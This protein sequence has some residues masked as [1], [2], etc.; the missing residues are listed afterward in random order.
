MG[1]LRGSPGA[2]RAGDVKRKLTD[3]PHGCKVMDDSPAVIIVQDEGGAYKRSPRK[4]GAEEPASSSRMMQ[5]SHRSGAGSPREGNMQSMTVQ[6][7]MSRGA[8]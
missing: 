1:Y 4:P 8:L 2:I 5:L 7:C 3:A 6:P